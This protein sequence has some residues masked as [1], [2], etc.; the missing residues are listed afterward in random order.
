MLLMLINSLITGCLWD[1]VDVC[2][3]ACFLEVYFE[4]S[5]SL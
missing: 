1:W 4:P 2:I 3:N 5:Y